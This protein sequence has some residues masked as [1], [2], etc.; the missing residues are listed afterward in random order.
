MLEVYKK[1]TEPVVRGMEVI[2]ARLVVPITI[3]NDNGPCFS[4]DAFR[5]FI[6]EWKI[7][8]ITSSPHYP[9]SNGLAERL[10]RTIKSGEKRRTTMWL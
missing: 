6:E 8:H 10:V 4:S 9:E 2:I 3:R 7:Y 5:R 1:N